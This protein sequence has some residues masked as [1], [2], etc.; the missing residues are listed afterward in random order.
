MLSGLGH[1]M[2]LDPQ[3]QE[4]ADCILNWL[5]QQRW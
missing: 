5:N 4:A 1:D 3:W 2:M